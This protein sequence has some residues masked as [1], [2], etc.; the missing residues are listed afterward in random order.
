[1][2]V[3]QQ[4]QQQSSQHHGCQQRQM[5]EVWRQWAEYSAHMYQYHL[6][7]HSSQQKQ[8]TARHIPSPQSTVNSNQ[9]KQKKRKKSSLSRPNSRQ[10]NKDKKRRQKDTAVADASV[11]GREEEME[12]EDEDL[13]CEIN[14]SEDLVRFLAESAKHRKQRDKAKKQQDKEMNETHYVEDLDK[15]YHAS[16]LAPTERPGKRRTA[17]MRMLYGKDAAMIHGMETAMQLTFDRN[18]DIQQPKHWPNLPI[19]IKF[20]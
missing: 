1:M 3:Q 8:P 7:Q 18:C 19:N 11:S 16:N 9:S 14:M 17:E 10:S 12:V 13:T 5:T 2:K 4:V 15:S 6:S 20:D